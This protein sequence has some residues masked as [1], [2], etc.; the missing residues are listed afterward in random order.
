MDV[1]A[2]DF[3]RAIDELV[4]REFAESPRLAAAVGGDGFDD[5]LDD[6][7][8]S[9]HERRERQD[10][11]WRQRFERFDPSDLTVDQAIDRDLVI[12]R[13]RVRRSLAGWEEWRRSPEAYLETGITGL[14][15]AAIRSEDELTDS[16]VARLHARLT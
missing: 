6:L 5:R 3:D 14:F 2:D 13:L 11:L 15:L 4:A 9:G 16:A 12:S 7:S 8:A 10:G 1:T